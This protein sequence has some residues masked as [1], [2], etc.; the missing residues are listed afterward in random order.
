[1]SGLQNSSVVARFDTPN[2]TGVSASSIL[3]IEE[4]STEEGSPS[5]PYGYAW[6]R[7]WSSAGVPTLVSTSG[8]QVQLVNDAV[9]ITLTET[10]TFNNSFTS[11]LSKTNVSVLKYETI[12]KFIDPNAQTIPTPNF[13]VDSLTGEVKA[14]IKCFGAVSFT[15]STVYRRYSCGFALDPNATKGDSKA[16]PPTLASTSAYAPMM[17]VASKGDLL[18]SVQL[19]APTRS[20]DP[21]NGTGAGDGDGLNGGGAISWAGSFDTNDG[22]QGSQFQIELISSGFNPGSVWPLR[23]EVWV[24]TG[25]DT[26]LFT[27]SEG[28]FEEYKFG[29]GLLG[30]TLTENPEISN[31]MLQW[32]NSTSAATRYIPIGNITVVTPPQSSFIA[33]HFGRFNPLFQSGEGSSLSTM[34]FTGSSIYK[35]GDLKVLKLGE[36]VTV[37]AG[38]AIASSGVARVS[39]RSKRKKFTVRWDRPSPYVWFGPVTVQVTNSEGTRSASLVINPPSRNGRL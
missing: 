6:V 4:D 7:V 30:P 11:N 36:V 9:S 22:S 32:S 21:R 26:P 16:T 31:E 19:T 29:G 37:N 33:K 12:G 3:K 23:A 39:Y 13:V 15:Y 14:N 1:M 10:I 35:I 27:T 17:V 2:S 38:L 20:S 25:N 24:Y 8:Q 5:C 34:V 28:E 18:D